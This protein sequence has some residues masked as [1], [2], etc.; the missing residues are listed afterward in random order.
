MRMAGLA[1]RL[2]QWL[3]FG[4][5]GVALVVACSASSGP[6]G[7][8]NS[9]G[10]SSSSGGS[11]GSGASNGS[12]GSA[13]Q[14]VIVS[15]GGSGAGNGAGGIGAG[16]G[17]AAQTYDGKQRP[18]DM[19]IMM[20]E[21]GSM[22]GSSWSAVTGAIKTFVQSPS[23]AGVGVGIQF[24]PPPSAQGNCPPLAAVCPQGCQKFLLFCVPINNPAECQINNYLPP[25]VTIQPLPGVKQQIITAMN[26][27]SPSG[28]TPTLPAMKSAVQA[29]EG[30]ATQYPTH[31]VIIVLA[32]DGQP[33]ACNSTVSNVAKVAQNGY[34]HVPSVETFVIGIGSGAGNLDQIAQKGGSTKAIIVDTSGGPQQ[35]LNTMNSIRGQA[36]GCEYLIPTGANAD[37]QKVNVDYTPASGGGGYLYYVGSASACGNNPGWYYDNAQNPKAIE[38]CPASCST[39]KSGGGKVSIVVGCQT[40]TPS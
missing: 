6:S 27:Q 18:L 20:D 15:T 37:P 39:V 35:F 14:G 9:G 7:A 25:P 36:L 33:N 12:G 40:K 31:K 32:T 10:S 16:G 3:V 19:Y 1:K 22:A 24:F 11:N 2:G 26:A 28:D 17:C 5:S 8:F 4:G 13:G 23:T 30:Y 34:N 29:T 21:S 38:L